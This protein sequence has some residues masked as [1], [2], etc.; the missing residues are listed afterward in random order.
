[1]ADDLQT[2]VPQSLSKLLSETLIRAGAHEAYVVNPGEPGFVDTLKTVSAEQASA[3]PGPGRKPI[4]SHANHVLYG[5]G[6]AQRAVDGDAHAFENADWNVAWRLEKVDAAQWTE[7]VRNLETAA[8][9]FVETMSQPREW[10]PILLTGASSIAA[11][12]A[13]HL[14]AVKQMLCDLDAPD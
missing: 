2:L 1:M 14:G 8:R 10:N 5:L 9:R 4:A 13:Y 12:T 6:L 3:P 7:L 11:H